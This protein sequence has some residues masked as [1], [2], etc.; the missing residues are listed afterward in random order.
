M[1][2]Y[3]WIK[4][5]SGEITQIC[6][7]RITRPSTFE[8]RIIGYEFDRPITLFSAPIK[9]HHINDEQAIQVYNSYC[10]RIMD[11]LWKK[12][13]NNEYIIM[14]NIIEDSLPPKSIEYK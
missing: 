6:G 1:C 10:K 4:T 12:F 13:I 3:V 5:L 11:A 2:N 7:A 9:E 14:E 8:M